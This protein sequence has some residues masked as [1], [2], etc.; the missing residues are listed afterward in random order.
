[1]PRDSKAILTFYG[2][3]QNKMYVEAWLEKASKETKE[4]LEKEN[5]FLRKTIKPNSIVLDVGCGTGR[6]LKVIAHLCKEAIG[7]DKNKKILNIAKENLK[8]FSQVKFVYGNVASL[9]FPNAYFDFV[10]C[11]DNTFGDFRNKKLALKEMARVL[12]ST[13]KLFLSVFNEKALVIRLKDYKASG[14]NIMKVD[15]DGTIWTKEGLVSK[16]FSKKELEDL[17][18]ELGLKHKIID[19]TQISYICVLSK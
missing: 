17:F 2:E 9:S 14:H 12:K 13:G 16:Q 6:N 15:R 8:E 19:F 7:I 4:W 3:R 18:D 5:E 10:I 1:M 11:M